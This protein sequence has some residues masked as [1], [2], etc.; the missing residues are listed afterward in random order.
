MIPDV[1]ETTI[2]DKSNLLSIL[3]NTDFKMILYTITPNK[4][5]ITKHIFIKI[6]IFLELFKRLG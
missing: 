4:N 5:A 2:P 6:G 1:I 3:D